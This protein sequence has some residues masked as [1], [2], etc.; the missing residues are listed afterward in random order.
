MRIAL[1]GKS[2]DSEGIACLKPLFERFSH[3]Q[4]SYIIYK[5]FYEVLRSE[6]DLGDNPALFTSKDVLKDKAD[7]LFSIGGDGTLLDTLTL[8][9]DS[10]IPVMGINLGRMG[11]LSSISKKD[12]IPAIDAIVSGEYVLD[13]REL[14]SLE[15]SGNLFG[16]L[17]FALNEL[18]INK[19]DTSS[20][21]LIHV[22]VD[23]KF[24]HAYWADGLIIS[25]PTGSTAYSLSCN[26]PIIAPD[27]AN[28]VITPIAT[29]NLTVRP[30]VIPDKSIIRIKV[31]GREK[32][33]LVSL[34]SR[35]EVI[36]PETEL[37][38]RKA[39]FRINL[40]QMKDQYFF[41]TIREKL[42]WG[43]DIRN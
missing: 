40:L 38:V 36:H 14:L 33:Y 37:L 3:H 22:Y 19:K 20:M 18:T 11:F 30:V 25:T 31:E 32:E 42:S 4:I 29:H 7:F 34:D 1:Y 21:I 24:L 2:A 41:R 16:E 13:S 35:S 39:N 15:T 12:I 23:E 26:G 17:N 10:G 6:I 5:P 28:F 43:Q 8:V 27:A 9:R